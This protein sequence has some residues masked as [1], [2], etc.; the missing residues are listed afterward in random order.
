MTKR[1]YAEYLGSLVEGFEIDLESDL[2]EQFYGYFQCF[3]PF[4]DNVEK[5]FEPLYYKNELLERL[6]PIYQATKSQTLELLSKRVRPGY[7]CPE[8]KNERENIIIYG[9]QHIAYLKE[10]AT[11]IED[12]ELFVILNKIT[13]IEFFDEEPAIEDDNLNSYLYNAISDWGIEN[14]DE[15]DLVSVLGEAYYSISCDYFLGYYFQYPVFKNK[16]SIDFLS[17]YFK[18]WKSGYQCKFDSEKLK[19]F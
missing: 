13:A 9:E 15:D 7:F 12:K 14:T 6:L 16:P 11:Y 10:F 18:I 17:P 2:A 4:G 8:Q 1:K 3:M 19:I 5:V